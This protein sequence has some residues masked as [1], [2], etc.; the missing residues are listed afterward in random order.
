[1]NGRRGQSAWAPRLAIA[2]TFA[3]L[4]CFVASGSTRL[5]LAFVWVCLALTAMGAEFAARR[6]SR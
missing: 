6:R 3:L 5:L 1:M 2:S 4:L